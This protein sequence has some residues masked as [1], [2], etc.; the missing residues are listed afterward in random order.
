MS[1]LMVAPY[2]TGYNF[3]IVLLSLF[4]RPALFL[5][6]WATVW[7]TIALRLWLA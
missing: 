7:I 2:V 6:A 4:D 5:V 3:V 1:S